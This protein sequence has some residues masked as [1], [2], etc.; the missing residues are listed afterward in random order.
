[1]KGQQGGNGKRRVEGSLD[2]MANTGAQNYNQRHKGGPAQ[3]EGSNINLEVLM[4][5]PCPK[6]GSREKPSK[7]LWKDCSIMKDFKRSHLFQNNNGLN[8]SSGSSSHGPGYGGGGSHSGFQGQ[9][10]QSNQVNQ[11]DYNQQS[12]QGNQ[13]QQ[14]SGY[15][16]NP[17]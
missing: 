5:Q 17:K 9:R 8:G 2:F 14:Q 15:H 13:Q 16:S 1:M 11:G 12:N 7:H 6:H 10:N 4:N 3:A